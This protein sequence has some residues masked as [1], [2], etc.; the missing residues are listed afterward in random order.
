MG[1]SSPFQGSGKGV[2]GLRSTPGGGLPPEP[3]AAA[4]RSAV[5]LISGRSPGLR[6]EVSRRDPLPAVLLLWLWI[7]ALSRL[8]WLVQSWPSTVRTG[9]PF[10]PDQSR[11]R[12]TRSLRP[13]RQLPESGQPDCPAA[14]AGSERATHPADKRSRSS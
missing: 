8:P 6:A 5:S 10:L 11:C 9:F 4:H 13:S 1:G 3:T 12:G 14:R 2:G 7:T